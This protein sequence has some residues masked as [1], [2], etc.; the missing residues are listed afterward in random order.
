MGRAEDS[1]FADRGAAAIFDA[2]LMRRSRGPAPLCGMSSCA[3]RWSLVVFAASC[4]AVL[5]PRIPPRPRE[6]PADLI[7]SLRERAKPAPLVVA[8]RGASEGF[9]ENTLPAFAEAVRVGAELVE[10]DF[11]QTKDGVLVC[12]HDATL[13]R[14]TDARAVFGGERLAVA[15]RNAEDLARLDAGRWKHT[16]FAGTRIPTLAEA[17]DVIQPR[18]TTMI[19][20]KA[21]R[22]EDLVELLRSKRLVERVLV[23]SFDWDW[24]ATLHA[25]EPRIAIAALS[26]DPPSDARLDGVLRTGAAILH[27]D[28]RRLRVEDVARMRER[29]FLVCTY[30]IDADVALLGAPAL[31]LDLVTTN[32]PA[33]LVALIAGGQCRR[34]R[35]N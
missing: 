5:L 1:E 12:L 8:H 4:L 15:E 10:L 2:R 23:Q 21:G 27:W 25:L 16:R 35:T 19:E 26:G 33:R 29:G 30:T 9:P 28:H 32:V 22:A 11:H 31:G 17:L 6:D 3:P 14:T 18:A 34:G 24:L 13:D 20:H 7:A